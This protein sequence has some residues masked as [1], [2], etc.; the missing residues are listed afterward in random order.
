MMKTLHIKYLFLIL[1]AF[2]SLSCNRMEKDA[3]KAAELTNKSIEYLQELDMKKSQETYKK[4][5][6]IIN[7]YDEKGKSAD[8]LPLYKKYRDEEKIID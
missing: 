3:R 7:K 8:F 6:E 4:S 1:T 2:I 5:Q